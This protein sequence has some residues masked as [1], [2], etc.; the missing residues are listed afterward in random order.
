MTIQGKFDQINAWACPGKGEKIAPFTY[1]ARPLSED[2]VEVQ[3]SHCGI[4]YSDIH[5]INSEWGPSNYPVV[6][7]HEIVGTVTAAG[8]K[9]S[10]FKVGDRVGV[11][12]LVNA[13]LKNS[14]EFCASKKDVF[15]PE[16]VMTYNDKWADNEKSYGGYAEAIRLNSRLVFN[17]PEALPSE[18]AAP[19]MCA[20]VSVFAPM[21]R[22]GVQPGDT[23]G[24][25][26]IGG[27]GH[28]AL[29]Y[30]NKLGAEVYALSRS[31]E[32]RQECL[33]LGAT[34]YV[35][36]S[37][38]EQVKDLKN[39]L[40]FL[41]VANNNANVPWDLYVNLIKIEGRM[42]V[43]GV[44][45]ASS[46][47]YTGDIVRKSISITGSFVGSIH[48]IQQT[49]EFSAKHSI[50]PLI[51]EFSMSQVNEAVQHVKDGKVRFR[52][53]LKN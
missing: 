35:N 26:G 8:P 16:R 34:H 23:V 15:C 51:N 31:E 32:K 4:C 12:C 25:T 7:G 11:G 6:T 50:H 52:A 22:Y 48:E 36:T 21:L 44:P 27:L 5:V 18:Y 13:C 9:V 46:A 40:K 17:I 53:V 3:I 28:L 45:E 47:I 38:P 37:D 20:G 1:N 14:C 19:L 24:I 42:V 10:N 29:Q 2:D 41:I 43:L 33:D 30:A 39:K 49:L